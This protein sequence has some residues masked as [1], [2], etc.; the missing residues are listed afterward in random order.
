MKDGKKYIFAFSNSSKEQFIEKIAANKILDKQFDGSNFRLAVLASNTNNLK[1]TLN[2]FKSGER[3]REVFENHLSKN[4]NPK[5]AFVYSGMGP[6]WYGMGK[7]LF[8]HFPTYRNTI[9]ECDYIVSKHTNWSLINELNKN[10]AESKMHETWLAQPANFALQVA[11]SKLW[12]KWGIQPS[13]V[14]GHSIGETTAFYEAGVHTLE[15]AILINIHRGQLQHNLQGRGKMIAVGMEQTEIQKRLVSNKLTLAAINSANSLTIAGEENELKELFDSLPEEIFKRY[16]DVNIPYHSNCMHEI[17]DA[18]FYN[19][20]YLKFREVQKPVNLYSTTLG[21]IWNNQFQGAEY[22]WRNTLDTVL[23]KQ[24]V[25]RM[26]QNEICTF[27]E[28]G[29]HKVLTPSL[30]GIAKGMN[31]SCNIYHSIDRN[32][33]EVLAVQKTL[34]NLFCVGF[35]I[36]WEQYKTHESAMALT[37]N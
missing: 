33:S 7:E 30:K 27:L 16:L 22:W 17:K 36:N 2:G 5:I 10:E 35:D 29:P 23:F 24:T 28:I 25:E 14:V 8:Q 20:E 11:L 12:K 6:Q 32:S 4:A 1:D 37:D 21:G 26:I 19:L 15:E 31:K 3:N 9:E 13:A 18:L 34:C